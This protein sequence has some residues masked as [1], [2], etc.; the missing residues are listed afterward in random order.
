VWTARRIVLLIGGLLLALSSYAAYALFLGGID[1]VAPLPQEYLW[2]LNAPEITDPGTGDAAKYLEMAFGANCHEMKQP[3][4]LWLPDKGIVFAAGDF[5]IDPADGRVR[6]E[7]FSAAVFHKSKTPGGFPEISTIVCAVAYLTLKEPAR[8]YSDLNHSEVIAVEMRGKPSRE[9]KITNNRGTKETG[10][11][12]EAYINNGP[13]FFE[14]RTNVISTEGNVKLLDF[15]T[16]PPTEIRGHGMELFLAKEPNP[17]QPAAP[18]P[19]DAKPRSDGNIDR[20]LIRADVSMHFWVDARAGFLGGAPN[21]KNA[22]PIPAT[23]PRADDKT[24]PNKA[25]IHIKT[26]GPFDYDLIKEVCWFESPKPQEGR[27]ELS[28]P[29]RD[30]VHVTRVQLIDGKERVDQLIC[31]R[32]DLKFRKTLAGSGDN[33]TGGDKEIE[34][35]KA[36]RQGTKDITLVIAAET[37]YAEGREMFYR[38]GDVGNGPLTTI[39]GDIDRPMFAIKS[40]HKIICPE[41]HLFAANRA[42]DGQHAWAKGPGKIWLLD[43]KSTAKEDS[44]PTTITWRD[45]LTVV[46]EKE[47]GQVFDLITV[48]GDAQFI[49]KAE[50]GA[51]QELHGEKIM[52]WIKQVQESTDKPQASGG[53]KQE[54]HRVFAEKNVRGKSSG[55]IIRRANFFTMSFP[56]ETKQKGRLPIFAGNEPAKNVAKSPAERSDVPIPPAVSATPVSSKP[57]ADNKTAVEEKKSSPPIELEGN[58][59]TMVIA[60]TGPKKQLQEMIAKGNVLVFQPGDKVGEKRIDIRGQMLTVKEAGLDTHILTVYGDKQ[61]DKQTL[62]RLEMGE[63]VLWGPV[64]VIDQERNTVTVDGAGAMQLPS[65]K[66]L[67]GTDLPKANAGRRVTVYWN[68]NMAF[69][70]KLATFFGG[71]QAFQDSAYSYLKCEDMTVTLDRFVSLKEGQKNGQNAKMDHIH[72][73][74]NVYVS[75]SKVKIDN[76]R[77]K[78]KVQLVQHNIIEGVYLKSYDDDRTFVGAPGRVRTLGLGGSDAAIG[79]GPANA[80]AKSQ[81]WK[82]TRVDFSESMVSVKKGDTRNATFYGRNSGVVVY[83]FPTTDIMANMNV[84]HPPKDGMYMQCDFLQVTAQEHDGKTLHQMVAKGDSVYFKTD[85]YV[86]TANIITF[87]EQTDIIIFEA[88]PG[89]VVRMNEVVGPDRVRPMN[90]NSRK[91]LYNRRTGT[92]DGNFQSISQ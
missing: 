52:A 69:D 76:S 57:P 17:K 89:N 81:V 48:V 65:N 29:G 7:P 11:D 22:A 61:Q 46:R 80:D 31:D 21:A 75:D 47:G 56:P 24:P 88:T 82:Q 40:G 86:G 55:F 62:A 8:E 85:K 79:P 91:V 5:K 30:Q 39:I 50:D 35:A 92:M 12:I 73:D 49:D 36:I 41:L 10:D 68:K 13:L 78:D 83:H 42:G 77:V 32:L 60:T 43:T 27:P 23:G 3:L 9:I 44:F 2:D 54:L 45:K 1:G 28:S 20:I 66:N 14:K 33:G 72:C 59:I 74:K 38:A 84:D 15:K 16:Q 34:T 25:H 64:V 87:N 19:K 37:I 71:I 51:T 58:E 63:M 4:Q 53:G 26:D 70:G 67:D 90:F 6:L 18:L